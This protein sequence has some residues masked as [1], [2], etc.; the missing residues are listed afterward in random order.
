[1]RA[2]QLPQSLLGATGTSFDSMYR[3]APQNCTP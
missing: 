1:M 2:E 3:T